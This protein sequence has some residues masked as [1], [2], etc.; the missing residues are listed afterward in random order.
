MV[1]RGGVWWGGAGQRHEILSLVVAGSSVQQSDRGWS[2]HGGGECREHCSVFWRHQ[3]GEG[4]HM[5]KE[6]S[7]PR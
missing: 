4:L 3:I 6:E 1:G 7:L 2:G 5:A